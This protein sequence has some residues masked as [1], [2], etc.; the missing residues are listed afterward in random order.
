ME[1]HHLVLSLVLSLVSSAPAYTQQ[2]IAPIV[3][4][5]EEFHPMTSSTT[6]HQ[7]YTQREYHHHLA[8]SLVLNLSLVSS[9]PAYTQQSIV[10][11][12]PHQGDFHPMTSSTS[13][14]Q[15]YTQREYHH[16]L[17]PC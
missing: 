14:H 17:A 6:C 7:R 10:P 1:Y 5:Q 8:L 4:H 12:V 9:A 16:H 2:S 3:P 13:C 15:R 11:I